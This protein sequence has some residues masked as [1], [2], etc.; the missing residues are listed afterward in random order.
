MSGNRIGPD[1][2][3]IVGRQVASVTS[4]PDYS[5]SLRR[6]GGTWTE[7][8]LNEFLKAPSAFCPGTRMDF[9]RD[10]SATERR[11]ILSYLR[12]L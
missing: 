9:P 6:V 3:G 5:S 12:T 8:R 10:V 1:L 7:E 11:A 2:L 4:Y